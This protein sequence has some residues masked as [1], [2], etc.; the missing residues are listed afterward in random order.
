M[1]REHQAELVALAEEHGIYILS[2][3]VYLLEHDPNDRL[4]A[5]A[6]AY[7]RGLS[8]VTLSKPW[9]ACGGPLVG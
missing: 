4:P 2:D 3:E 1:S 5:M 7:Q 8:C 6:D 9:G